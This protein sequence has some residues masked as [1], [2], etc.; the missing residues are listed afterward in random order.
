MTEHIARQDFGERLDWRFDWT[1]WLVDGD[2][3]AASQWTS[4]NCTVVSDSNDTTATRVVVESAKPRST[5]VNTI[6][7]ANG[8]IRDEV[9]EFRPRTETKSQC[10][11]NDTVRLKQGVRQEVPIQIFDD[12]TETVLIDF[13]VGYT[14]RAQIRTLNSSG[15]AL[16]ELTSDGAARIRL[17]AGVAPYLGADGEPNVVL[18]FTDAQS[19]ALPSGEPLLC[20]LEITG[21]SGQVEHS[22]T[23]KIMLEKEITT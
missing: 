18:E 5:A 1:S 4:D 15:S 7:T 16:D 8:L 14:A 9:I 13:S 17:S 3:I 10:L 11:T 21:P 20:G 2:T 12:E 19:M 6:T 23:L 22:V